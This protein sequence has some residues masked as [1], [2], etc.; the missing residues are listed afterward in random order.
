MSAEPSSTA[1]QP[2]WPAA[3][4]SAGA[5][6]W[7][8]PSCL[9]GALAAAYYGLFWCEWRQ[10]PDLTHAIFTPLLFL[11]LVHESRTRGPWRWLPPSPGTYAALAGALGVGLLLLAAGGL[12]AA[13]LDWSH[14]LVGSLL[15]MA[16]AM[17]LLAAWWRLADDRVRVIPLNWAAFAAVALWPLSAP[18]P[19]GTY[20][21]LTGHLQLLVSRVTLHVLHLLAVPAVK[22]QQ[23]DCAGADLAWEVEEAC[24]S[25][26]A[27]SW[28]A[29]WRACFFRRRSSAARRRGGCSWRWRRRWR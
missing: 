24:S 26:R 13:A 8:P 5:R 25:T 6:P 20:T 1:L 16:L 4:G 10:N 29:W 23:R 3:L 12:Y 21:R 27:A 22:Q 11:V 19:P 14:A 28:P 7:S 9:A 18:I 15:A 2:A 17:L